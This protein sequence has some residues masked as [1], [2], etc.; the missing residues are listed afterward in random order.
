MGATPGFALG[1]GLWLGLL[2]H[3]RAACPGNSFLA[4]TTDLGGA[5]MG[6][7]LVCLC[8]MLCYTALRLAIGLRADDL[9]AQRSGQ[10]SKRKLIPEFLTGIVVLACF[11]A[12]IDGY[13]TRYCVAPAGIDF[14]AGFR[15]PVKTYGWNEIRR[16]TVE[17]SRGK[18]VSMRFVVKMSDGFALDLAGHSFWDRLQPLG[19]ALTAV[20]AGLDLS[21]V[22]P[23]CPNWIRAR[24]IA[25]PSAWVAGK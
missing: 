24:L 1:A 4:G 25:G 6:L 10:F 8:V 16:I 17:C 23:S 20:R 9:D 14:G 7:S 11:A 22:Q 13:A 5:E 3:Q 18:G 19:Y 12:L 15:A 21:A 2:A